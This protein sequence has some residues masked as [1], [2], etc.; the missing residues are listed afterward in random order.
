MKN[1]PRVLAFHDMS[2]YGKCSLTVALPVIS[3]CGV[4]VCPLPTALLSSNTHFD[5]F[6]FT[7]FTPHIEAYYSHWAAMDLQ[8]DALYSG[9]IGSFLQIEHLRRI[10]HLFAPKLT[11]IDP[12]MGDNGV[13]YKT[14]TPD[15]C[16]GMMALLSI[17]DVLTPNLTEASFLCGELYLPTDVTPLRME[18]LCRTLQGFGARNI[19]LTGIERGDTLYN[20]V[21]SSDGRYTECA[22]EL[23][24]ERMHGTG[25]LFASVLTG[26][27]L[28]GAGLVDAVGMAA[29]FVLLAMKES[30]QTEGYLTRG[31]CFEPLLHLLRQNNE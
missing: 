22:I 15:M 26:K 31:V 27:L 9:F 16:A 29:D 30:Y 12:V 6:T 23:L 10:R 7:D 18:S 17:A 8:V 20:C 3:A 14:Y 11:V 4:E 13:I 19:V 5:G 2:G 28:T 24:R 25:D 1:L 21:L